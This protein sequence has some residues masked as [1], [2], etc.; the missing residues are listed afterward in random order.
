VH[1]AN[2]RAFFTVA[3][4]GKWRKIALFSSALRP[5]Q[6]KNETPPV[7]AGRHDRSKF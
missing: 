4:N 7:N 3:A 2:L 6:T 1:L 5:S